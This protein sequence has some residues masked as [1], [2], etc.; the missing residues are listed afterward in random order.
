MGH[1]HFDCTI[2]DAAPTTPICY[3]TALPY[4]LF[5]ALSSDNN[6]S[7]FQLVPPFFDAVQMCKTHNRDHFA[8]QHTQLLH[9][10][11]HSSN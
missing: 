9:Q 11:L 6:T 3:C 7:G 2:K 4:Q 10:K 8:R 5:Y 1:H